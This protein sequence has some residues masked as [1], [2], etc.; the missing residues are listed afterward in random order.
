MR[1]RVYIDG[2]NFYYGCL[3]HTPYK[4][5]DLVHLF[6]NHLLPRSGATSS[7]LHPEHGI[8]FY[9]AEISPRAAQ[10]EH[11][12]QDQRS[13][14]AALA[15]HHPNAV[16]IKI[17]KGSYAIDKIDAR[18][19]ECC[20]DGKEKEPKYCSTVKVWK[21]EEKQSDVNIAI[22]AVFDAF[23]DHSIEQVVFAT[24]DTDIVPALKKLQEL[25]AL[26][27]RPPIK[28][29]LVTPAK[30]RHGPRRTNKSL[31]QLADWTI[32]FITDKELKLSQLPCRVTGGKKPAFQPVSW[33]EHREQVAE[34]LSILS[35]CDVC[36]SVPKAWRWLCSPKPATDGLPELAEDPSTMLYTREG[37]EAVL[38]HAKCFAE[39]MRNNA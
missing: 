37:V 7:E 22:D 3:K 24:N 5:L 6:E 35:A 15:G 8:K 19:V 2:Y 27:I 12:V 21:L 31:S 10:D 34:L 16:K 13:Y 28:I 17:V 39:H 25:N 4:W 30:E 23:T 33:F 11:S 20:E 1:T 18:K 32:N 38:A 14:H 9:T 36:G 26:G 29:G